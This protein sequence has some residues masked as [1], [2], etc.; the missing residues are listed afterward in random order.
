MSWLTPFALYRFPV[1]AVLHVAG[2]RSVK[3]SSQPQQI[4]W[5]K[6]MA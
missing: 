5:P 4:K 1:L 3:D 2:I 6:G